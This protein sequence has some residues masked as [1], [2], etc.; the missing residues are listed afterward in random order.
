MNHQNKT[1]K[2]N[3]LSLSLSLVR[4]SLKVF[5]TSSFVFI[6]AALL[7]GGFFAPSSALA[8]ATVNPASGGVNIS[9][10]TTSA[11]GGSEVYT[12]LSG[13]SITENLAG[14]ISAGT[15]TI[16]LPAGWEF[17][18]TSNIIIFKF[19]G[20][21]VLSSTS[22][23]PTQTSFSFVVTSPSTSASV[24]GFSGLKV[25]PTGT[26]P[27]S[28][29]MTYSGAGIVG[30]SG[31]T[32]FGTLSTVPGTVTQLAFTIQPGGAVY[33]SL[34]SPQPVVVTQ[35]QF[36][37]DSTNGS[38][39]KTATLTLTTGTGALLGTSAL[40]ISSGTATFADLT[41]DEFGA[42]K[43]LTAAASGLTSAVSNNF[44][45]TKKSL[46]ATATVDGKDYDGNTSTT[47]LNVVLVGVES[48]DTVTADLTGATATFTSA[49]AGTQDISVTGVIL[50]GTDAGNYTLDNNDITG[51][52]TI[53]QLEITITPDAD[54]TKIYGENDP[55]EF[56]FTN[57]PTLIGTDAFSGAL[58]RVAGEDVNTYAY[59]LGTLEDGLDNYALT[60]VAG[61]FE[62]TKKDLTV[63][64]VGD[65]REYDQTT[66]ATVTLSSTDE[67]IGDNLV[68][69][70][71]SALF[72]DKTAVD[73]KTVNV[74][75][76]SI[77]GAK[78]GNYNLLNTE[79][80][81]TA[82]ITK[83]SITA[84]INLDNKTYNGNTNAVYSSTN[85][86]VANGVIAGD[87]VV[88]E[89]TGSKA[90][91]DKHVGI[92]KT[93]NATGLT[94]SGADKD[95]Y[96]FDGTGTGTATISA[97]PITVTAVTDT[98]TYNG[99]DV[100]TVIP[101]IT[102]G[103]LQGSDTAGF[104]E[105]FDT[106]HFGI[107]KVLTPSGSV[108]DGNSG[109]NYTVTF[110]TVS[111]GE[112]TKKSIN[113]TAQPD[114]K[115]YD[116]T[117]SSD[118]VPVVDPLETL[119][120]VATPPT[121]SYDTKDKG[122]GK[123]LT[124]SGLVITDGNSG[125]NYNVTYVNDTTGVIEVK[126]LTVDGA[127]SVEKIYNGEVND[128]VVNFGGA[129]LNGVVTGEEA[130][131]SLNSTGYSA[132]YNNKNVDTGKTVTVSVL[133]L[134]GAGASNYSLT[135]PVLNDGV[136]TERT[137][138]V[139]ANGTTKVYDSTLDAT[140]I[141][142]LSD[143]RVDGDVLTLTHTAAFL[144][145]DVADGKDVNVTS[146][147]ITGGT[148]AGNYTLNGVTTAPATADITPATL[149]ATITASD[150]IYDGNNSATIT[151]YTPVDVLGSD[152]IVL[153][154]GEATFNNFNVINGNNA[155]SAT[156]IDIT[157]ADA[158]NYTYDGTA[159]G[160]ANI[161]PLEITGSF[162]ADN[163]TYDGNTSAA[164][165][166][167]IL[168]GVLTQDIGDVV[169]TGGT[170]EFTDANVNDDIIVTEIVAMT[171]TGSAADN[172][173]LTGVDTTTA[174][175][176][177]APLTIT[178][179]DQ[180]R[181]YG[182]VNPLLTATYVGFVGGEDENV[183]DTS[184]VLATDADAT[185][186][187]GDY[188]ITASGA[189][190]NN[191]EITHNNGTLTVTPATLIVT[192]N[193]QSKIYGEVDPEFTYV[194]SGFKN[195]EDESVF[196]G[197]LE[198][199]NTSEN[200]GDYAISKGSLLAGDNYIITFN[201]DDLTIDQRALTVTAV[202]DTK[203]YDGNATSG[204]T[205]TIT[206]GV[207][208]FSDEAVFS[209]TFDNPNVGA[210]VLT[211]SG[212]V[213]DGNGGINYTYDFSNTAVGEITEL[214]IVITPDAGQN[215]VYGEDDPAFT[216]TFT[217]TLIGDDELSGTLSRVENEDVGTYAYNLDT[218]SAGGNYTLTLALGTF[219]ITKA[220]PVITWGNP[221]DIVYGT[222]LSGTELNAT[223]DVD[224]TFV[225][226]PA[227][228]TVLNV[229][230]AQELSVA[231]TPT[232]TLNYENETDDVL[233][234]ITKASLTVTA[235]NK[236]KEYLA[237]D[238]AL[239]Y[240]NSGLVNGDTNAVFTGTLVRDEGELAGTYSILQGTLL[241]GGNYNIS[242]TPGTFTVEDTAMPTVVSHTPSLNA[243]NIS[244]TTAIVVTFSEAVVVEEADVSFNPVISGGF[245][246]SNSGT[247]VVTITP[248]N[249]LED[250][251]TYTITLNG[252]EDVN[253]NSLPTYSNIKFT[254]ATN[255]SVELNNNGSGWNLI[256]LPVVPSNTA[257]ATGLGEA[258]DDIDAVWTY[259]PTNPNAV[260]GWLVFVPRHPQGT[261]NLTLMTTGFG[262]W[263]SVTGNANLSGS[264]TLLIA[265]PTPPPSRALQ[266]GWN[267]IGYYQLPNEDNS[268]PVSAFAS[269]GAPGVGYNGLWGFDNT[270]G[271]FN[272]V[273]TIN[274]GDAFWISLPSVK[275]YT[276]SNL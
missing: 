83:K 32:N 224:G 9:I 137:L 22:V 177:K 28:N 88:V 182:D 178:A 85:P 232:D 134:D 60:L 161:T 36:G 195:G 69:S 168:T 90:F 149:T 141:V 256:S 263:V 61:T 48:E 97:R 120:T 276:P 82:N 184:V 78:S 64:A 77:S 235:E 93:V 270:T 54:Q 231:F 171:L 222:A 227:L 275:T 151:G 66:N 131:V 129:S 13:P 62:I 158:G 21:I 103:A 191:Y 84:T 92:G 101:A 40:D 33:G 159:T 185:S 8:A 5:K 42:G 262:Y 44:E 127:I 248:N 229:G 188:A 46:T 115:V 68:Y 150:K 209:Q 193:P 30:V 205:P 79:A 47:N 123:T 214:E 201:S 220:T 117:T 175:I 31:S 19:G 53:N 55:I 179:N 258:A 234:N 18:I 17:D 200:V 26:T 106:K 238:P 140:G 20:N 112:I 267:L 138:V 1:V 269:I 264:G 172:Y 228:G 89:N 25:R 57:L 152:V 37:N 202:T 122:T 199:L 142:T 207:L 143:D 153:S 204:V 145:K 162:T 198:R 265:G 272:S 96:A 59:T 71:T 156:G 245:I 7:V 75:G 113:V 247:S 261:N 226:T 242:Y 23:T 91:I 51:T 181:E 100:S 118:V 70:Y 170:A 2:V 176:T 208:Q 189:T 169:L 243:L 233:I 12:E 259:D 174:N 273:T 206:D 11:P 6:A 146:I 124:P 166:A 16:T 186:N 239:T 257:I 14:D 148:D 116:G 213:N 107:E 219:E 39:G 10:D 164:I 132:T 74:S 58:S 126:E 105:K 121:Q 211:A 109:A 237:T 133:T 252:A 24:L 246:I 218:L 217:P 38:S 56:T 65:N 147:A 173:A 63:S 98:R 108:N 15:H 221:A 183:L 165:L 268:T 80:V 274:P 251:T 230:N 210:R 197:E 72:F 180:E 187:V 236:S 260:N 225:Y 241:A 94:L 111:T 45:I 3:S 130:L 253:G 249:P 266:T 67:K 144:T 52:G 194:A 119:D 216:Y 50:D 255:Y 136:I 254:T 43:Q 271:F 139:T 86:R 76:I 114:T 240:T 102:F 95:N 223:A 244:P 196:D 215:K 190:D 99:T 49:D 167:Q 203:P 192:A 110:D 128:A 4:D 135:Q 155:V 104:T 157:G 41:V 27:S 73:G 81:T 87:D 154:G 212:V 160:E 250:N 163:K 35:D 125:L 34:L 29:N